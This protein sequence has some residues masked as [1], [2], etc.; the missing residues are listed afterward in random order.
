MTQRGGGTSTDTGHH[1]GEP[2]NI[3]P[4]EEGQTPDNWDDPIYMN[5]FERQI[6]GEKAN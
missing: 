6:F 1:V 3:L 4:G 5:F 2:Q